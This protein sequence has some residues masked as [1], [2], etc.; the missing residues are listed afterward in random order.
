VNADPRDR[1]SDEAYERFVSLAMLCLDAGYDDARIRDRTPFLVEDPMFNAIWAWSAVALS[2]IA[3]VVGEDGREAAEDAERIV[4]ALETKLWG[5][6]HGRFLPFDARRG[7]LLDHRSIVSFMPIVAPG[8]D[9]TKARRT[10]RSMEHSRHCSESPCYV[11]PTYEAGAAG[12]DAPV[13]A[14]THL[15]QH[16][17]AAV[18]RLPGHRRRGHGERAPDLD[19]GAH[20]RERLP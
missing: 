17:L 11:L 8:L 18:P 7:A 20:R 14:R 10:V 3:G 6:G 1:P 12:Y 19:P 5:E 9:A 15:D 13:L 2:E 16:R 4:A